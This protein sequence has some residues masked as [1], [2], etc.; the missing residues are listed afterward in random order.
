MGAVSEFIAF[1]ARPFKR[2]NPKFSRFAVIYTCTDFTFTS[3][4]ARADFGFEP[5]YSDEEALERTIAF[6]KKT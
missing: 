3:G 2:Y 6:F 4:K 5:K 1:M